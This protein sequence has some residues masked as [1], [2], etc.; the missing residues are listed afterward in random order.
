M[1]KTRETKVPQPKPENIQ[2]VSRKIMEQN[3]QNKVN[4]FNPQVGGLDSISSSISLAQ[5]Q[6]KA[7]SPEFAGFSKNISQNPFQT[8]K[9]GV[10]D[11]LMAGVKEIG[12]FG[13]NILGRG[14][15]AGR[16]GA[17]LPMTAE[18]SRQRAAERR[19]KEALAQTPEQR[20]LQQAA[21]LPVKSSDIQSALSTAKTTSGVSQFTPQQFR[22]L[23]DIQM[24]AASR[25]KKAEF[26]ETEAQ[27]MAAGAEAPEEIRPDVFVSRKPKETATSAVAG[28]DVEGPPSPTPTR[29]VAGV[30]TEGPP[31]PAPTAA[32]AGV[33]TE[34]PPVPTA[35]ST[36]TTGAPGPDGRVEAAYQKGLARQE[37][38]IESE[39]LA[40][41]QNVAYLKA[42]ASEA[43][44]PQE[45]ARLAQALVTAERRASG[46]ASK[47]LS[48]EQIRGMA[49]RDVE[50]ASRTPEQKAAAAEKSAQVVAQLAS[51]AEKTRA[52]EAL[53]AK[54]KDVNKK[55]A[56]L[57]GTGTNPMTGAA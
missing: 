34:G 15:G 5:N 28:V 17:M 16:Y 36:P 7:G 55:T 46:E 32:V 48:P 26:I 22:A 24:Q 51:A 42:R 11:D 49:Q 12:E 52:G 19:A 31:S 30:D 25:E 50:R 45:K 21:G 4:R 14:Q 43:K 10:F 18:Q 53:A 29:A 13:T 8:I 41:A 33:D 44:T 54:G 20:A 47:S 56:A 2:D 39:K 1:G 23:Q 35:T 9:E 57:R 3:Q 40:G 27:R 37:R 38:R 6:R